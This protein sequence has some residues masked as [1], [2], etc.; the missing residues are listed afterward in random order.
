MAHALTRNRTYAA[1]DALG[2]YSNIRT[3]KHGAHIKASDGDEQYVT[4]PPAPP[5]GAYYGNASIPSSYFGWQSA[6]N[7]SKID[8]FSAAC[9]MF[10]QEL[11]DIAID[12]NNTPPVLGLIQSAWGGTEIDVWLKNTTVSKC[13]NASGLPETNKAAFGSLWN[14]MVAP[15]I[16]YT[17]FGALWYQG[18][19]N[20]YQCIDAGNRDG[21]DPDNLACGNVLNSTGYACSMKNLVN[22]WRDEWSVHP[23]TT[24]ATFPFGIVSLAAGTSEGH[25]A[26]MPVFRHAQTASYGFLPGPKGSGM[27]STFIAQAYDA[28]DPGV[29]YQGGG[30]HQWSELDS[31]YQAE[32]DRPFPGRQGYSGAGLQSFTQ[33]YMG[34]LHPRAKQTIGRRLALAAANVAYSQ[35]DVPFTGPVIKTC[36]VLKANARC[37]PGQDITDY[38]CQQADSHGGTCARLLHPFLPSFL[39]FFLRSCFFFF[40]PLSPRC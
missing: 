17:I 36:N 18:E 22:S 27:E 21:G 5:S 33:Q 26:T 28:G 23:G 40:P 39:S 15:F 4:P 3:Y 30:N 14:G 16:N 13:A 32:Y 19:N 8:E 24:S 29:R 6:L 38:N 2:M 12:K 37:F 35:A 25:G 20:V 11:T 31:P 9:W 7:S 34:G 10:A 1:V